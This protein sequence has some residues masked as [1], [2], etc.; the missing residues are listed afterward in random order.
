MPK[1][2]EPV[3]APRAFTESWTRE[4]AERLHATLAVHTNAGSA[5]EEQRQASRRESA[6]LE[7]CVGEHL[8]HLAQTGAIEPIDT[9]GHALNWTSAW[10]AL[11]TESDWRHPSVNAS[12]NFTIELE[13]SL[14]MK[15]LR[16]PVPS[17]DELYT[18]V[19]ERVLAGNLPWRFQETQHCFRTGDRVAA[20]ITGWSVQLGE[21][22]FRE[23]S[24]HFTP[25]TVPV[26]PPRP[27]HHTLPVP[28]GELWVADWCR[29]P[30]LAKV[31]KA[32]DG[33]CETRPPPSFRDINSA[34][35]RA[36]ATQLYARELG[37]GYVSVGSCDQQLVGH[38][39]CLIV[40]CL[41][42]DARLSKKTAASVANDTPVDLGRTC[43]DLWWVSIAD[44][45]VLHDLMAQEVGAEAADREMDAFVA[46]RPY[47]FHIVHVP[48]G[49]YHFYAA[50][51]R[52]DFAEHLASTF[53]V[54]HLD[55]SGI[56]PS[57]ILS[58][59]PLA[60]APPIP[61]MRAARP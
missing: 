6:H 35:G 33:R 7:A 26:P 13:K 15:F 10:N 43:S 60:P 23:R 56:A 37:I 14:F 49:T 1:P 54:G 4:A 50:A 51:D 34:E 30:S 16:A 42:E 46:S 59:E 11:F 47:G 45:A 19:R 29:M 53:D 40:G 44:R 61:S 41:E 12:R 3:A 31:K 20:D 22:S 2:S 52:Q 5:S 36:Q 24:P 58:P 55:L 21:W 48:P 39:G 8:A 32:F 17:V 9:L 18:E 27:V 28:S 38:H 57:F 25:Y